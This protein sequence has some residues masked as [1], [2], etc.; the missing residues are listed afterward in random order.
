MIRFA[1]SLIL[2]GFLPVAANAATVSTTVE[3]ITV[4]PGGSID[5]LAQDSFDSSTQEIGVSTVD[6]QPPSAVGRSTSSAYYT[7]FGQTLGVIA[8]ADKTA[9][10]APSAH[11][12]RAALSTTQTY[13]ALGSGMVTV[14]LDLSGYISVV[15][16]LQDR[17][18]LAHALGGFFLNGPGFFDEK[19]FA[20]SRFPDPLFTADGG[21]FQTTL[22]SMFN[23]ADGEMFTLS[24]NFS[25][26]AG[27]LETLRQFFDADV[28]L[29]GV[30]SVSA[31]G[32]TLETG[33]GSIPAAVP[34][35][36]SAFFILAS[37]GALGAMRRA[38]TGK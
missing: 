37:L 17:P 7:D 18:S 25:A 11:N 12:A 29:S 23:I 19:I 20:T 1:T 30:L 28:E 14:S 24:A 9:T 13:R 32:F 21:A 8:R 34:L 31:D 15:S 27:K 35:P 26:H 10:T 4:Y 2:A 16:D 6:A 3:A 38:K 33:D 22:T 5:N 36:S